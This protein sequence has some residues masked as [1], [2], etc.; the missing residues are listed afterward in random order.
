MKPKKL[1]NQNLYVYLTIFFY[2]NTNSLQY[3]YIE[4][5]LATLNSIKS[6]QG[7]ITSTI[8]II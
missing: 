4:N 8:N 5:A 2:Q 6:F 7:I 1:Y 3:N